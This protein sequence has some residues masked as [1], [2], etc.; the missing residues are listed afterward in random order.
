MNIGEL[1]DTFETYPGNNTIGSFAHSRI[2]AFSSTLDGALTSGVTDPLG[3]LITAVLQ[4]AVRA[5]AKHWERQ[6]SKSHRPS[7]LMW[8]PIAGDLNKCSR[9]QLSQSNILVADISPMRLRQMAAMLN[10]LMMA[11]L[12]RGCGLS[13]KPQ[14]GDKFIIQKLRLSSL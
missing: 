7:V 6:W 8:I 4:R 2:S 10:S 13:N 12:M 14:D 3:S 11:M 5:R 9:A 1:S